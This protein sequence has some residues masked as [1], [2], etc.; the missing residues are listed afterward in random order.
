MLFAKGC[1]FCLGLN[2]LKEPRINQFRKY[3]MTSLGHSELNKISTDMY[4]V[5]VIF[6][7]YSLTLDM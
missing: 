5:W 3:R 6:H 4:E 7:P 1:P 2:V